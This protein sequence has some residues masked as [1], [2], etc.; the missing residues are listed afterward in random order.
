MR[1]KIHLLIQD[2]LIIVLSVLFAIYISKTGFLE[3]ILT[4]TG[5]VQYL[6]S[7]IAGIFFTSVFTIA[8]AM[9]ALGEISQISHPL[10]VAISGAVGALI[11]DLI[12]FH[13]IKDRFSVHIV[14]IMRAY[15]PGKRFKDVFKSHILRKGSILLGGLIIASPLPDELGISL[16]G[17]SKTNDKWFVAISLAFNFI[18]IAI[19]AIIAQSLL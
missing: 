7:F 1:H 14:N 10:T 12:I 19:V 18:G 8:P 9:V 11:G 2:L 5:E 3:R 4:A 6:G 16:L 15:K 17:F 13:F